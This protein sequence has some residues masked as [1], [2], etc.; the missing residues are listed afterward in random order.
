V[1]ECWRKGKEGKKEE[2][3]LR[4]GEILLKIERRLEEHSL[5]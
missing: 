1:R 2:R 4:N 3:K 5:N